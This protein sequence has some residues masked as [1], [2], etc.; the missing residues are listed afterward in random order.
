MLSQYLSGSHE[1]LGT[2]NNGEMTYTG[3][4]TLHF[5]N[6][7]PSLVSFS[8]SKNHVNPPAPAD[9][10]AGWSFGNNNPPKSKEECNSKPIVIPAPESG[11]H[12]N[13]NLW[14]D[15]GRYPSDGQEVEVVIH[16]IEFT[17]LG[18]E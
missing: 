18:S 4:K 7:T 13:I 16:S 10:I 11:T 1:L 15:R 6:C 9:L 5:I 8:S 2:P 17:A 14:I 3:N 12:L